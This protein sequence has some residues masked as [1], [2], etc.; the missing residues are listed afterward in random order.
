M[1]KTIGNVLV[2][3]ALIEVKYPIGGSY[4]ELGYTK[5]GVQVEYSAEEADIEV[6]EESFPIQSVITKEKAAIICN[7]AEA[8]LYN[9]DK[10]IPGSVYAGN[11]ITIG[12]GLIKEMSVRVTGKNPAGFNRTIECPLCVASGDAVTLNHRKGEAQVVACK[13]KVLKAQGADP[14][15]VTDS[16]S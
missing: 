11:V 7:V 6:E 3:V 4:V 8:S 1:A 15:K 10:A 5:D 14:F 16:T 13:F 2:G 9:L 12:D